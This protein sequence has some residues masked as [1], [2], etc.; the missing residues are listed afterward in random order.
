VSE[1]RRMTVRVKCDEDSGWCAVSTRKD[2]EEFEQ[3][4]A[5]CDA[6]VVVDG[7][8]EDLPAS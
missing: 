7:K 8:V 3:A 4:H 6:V 1:T 5:D 2:L